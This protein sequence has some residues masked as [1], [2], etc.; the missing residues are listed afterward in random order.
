MKLYNWTSKCVFVIFFCE[1]LS[2]N[3]EDDNFMKDNNENLLHSNINANDQPMNPLL[4]SDQKLQNTL[5]DTITASQKRGSKIVELKQVQIIQ[6][7]F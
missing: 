7:C 5:D 6:L 4:G 1:V 3:Q 2:I